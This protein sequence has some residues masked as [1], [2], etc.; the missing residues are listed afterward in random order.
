MP[1]IRPM[2]KRELG[3][4]VCV[5]DCL[6]SPDITIRRNGVWV[7]GPNQWSSAHGECVNRSAFTTEH[8]ETIARALN[9]SIKN[10]EEIHA[11]QSAF[12]AIMEVERNMRRMFER[13]NS[14]FNANL[15]TDAVYANTHMD[16]N[17]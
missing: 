2:K 8:Y 4:Y 3:R 16:L 10:M 5:S 15:F 6:H 7:K 14:R 12:A 17:T 1:E 11:D 13:D 9:T